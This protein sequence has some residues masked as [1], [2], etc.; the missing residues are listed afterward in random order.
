MNLL[1]TVSAT[2]A[3][4]ALTSACGL[5]VPFEWTSNPQQVN[6]DELLG[7]NTFNVPAG[8]GAGPDPAV[9]V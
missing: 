1:R 3:L 7:E 4:T 8:E 6:V 9:P 5:P 2:L